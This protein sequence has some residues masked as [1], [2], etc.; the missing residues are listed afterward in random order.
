MWRV[1]LYAQEIPGRRGRARLEQ[2]AA[3]LAI[4][5]ARRPGWWHVATFADQSWGGGWRP[6]LS[7]LLAAAPGHYDVV[8]VDT[9][10]AVANN[11]R[12]RARPDVAWG[13][14]GV[15]GR[16]RGLGGI[17]PVTAAAPR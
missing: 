4:S 17:L 2:Q 16:R 8:A 9:K 5:V 6:G 15:H 14:A 11:P 12:A 1:A 10:G 3:R 13:R 7:G